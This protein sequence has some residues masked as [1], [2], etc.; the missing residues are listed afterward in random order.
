MK[1]VYRFFAVVFAFALVLAAGWMLAAP[2]AQAE[3]VSSGTCGAN[4]HV[5]WTLDDQG[6][7]T[8]RG[9][10]EMKNY[11]PDN[12]APWSFKW[13]TSV[14]EVVI[15]SGVTSIGDDAFAGCSS[16]TN[17]TIPDSVTSIGNGAFD[18]CR[19]LTSI[20]IPDGVTS[21]GDQAFKSCSSLTSITIPEGV[22]SIGNYAFANCSSLTS[23]TIPDGVTSIGDAAFSYCSRLVSITIPDGVTSIGLSAFNSCSN[24]T[25]ITIPDGVTSISSFTFDGCSSL[26]SITIPDSVTS[27]GNG[28]LDGC[29]SLTSITIPEGV[30]RIGDR[31]FTGCSSLTS[32]TIPDGVLSIGDQAFTGCSGLTSITIPEGVT[33]I[34]ESVFESCS[35]LTSI[36]IPDSVTSIGGFAFAYCS[37]IRYASLDSDGAKTLSKA[38]YSFRVPGNDF[39]LKYMYTEDIPSGFEISN[40]DKNVVDMTIPEDVTSIGYG[41]FRACSSMTSIT[42]PE[43]VTTISEYAFKDCSSLTSITIPNSVTSIDGSAFNDC[44]AIRYASIDS[45]GAKALGKAGYS[46][47]VP[48]SWFDLKYLYDVNTLTALEIISV[49]RGMVDVTIP[50]GVTS[51]GRY[52]FAYHSSLKSV[53]IPEG[54]TTIGEYA[55]DGCSSLTSITIPDGVTYIPIDVFRDCSSL[56]SISIPDSL[57]GIDSAF[58]GCSSLTSITIPKGMASIDWRTFNGCMLTKIE[59]PDSLK[60]I[61]EG[62]ISRNV[63]I[64]CNKYSEADYWAQENGNPIVYLQDIDLDAIREV[65]LP[66]TLRIEYGHSEKAEPVIFPTHDHPTVTWTSSDRKVAS[67][68]ADGRITALR[69]GVATITARVGSASASVEV[70]CYARATGFELPERMGAFAQENTP[71]PVTK[72]VPEGAEVN[73]TWRSADEK[74]ATVDEN[75]NVYGRKPGNEV[76]ITATTDDGIERSCVVRIL[77]AREDLDILELPANLTAIDREAFAGAACQ[78]VVVPEGCVSIG[79]RAFANCPNLIYVRIPTSVKTVAEDAFEGCGDVW[80]DQPGE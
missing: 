63:T 24:L 38:G 76:T 48:G 78:C 44:S 4:S 32:I 58:T 42:I 74:L 15:E 6:T 73:L 16:L 50:D 31:E 39:D 2:A 67:V 19:S 65:T 9:T 70:T 29:R 35:G 40:V 28:A 5:T 51:I 79:P 14:K 71:V 46:F 54:V 59:I 3:I 56:T 10:G 25:S 45:D 72:I 8:I 49:D 53:T 41:A 27:I 11:N 18:G 30:T 61:G 55:F 47:R 52:A 66:E 57:T 33:S 7:L 43:G 12:S 13:G 36:T 80:I 68:D 23:I 77:P 17:V 37:A 26:T 21:I 69:P 20:M 34:G 64:Y 75:G 62:A 1:R 22:T 60:T